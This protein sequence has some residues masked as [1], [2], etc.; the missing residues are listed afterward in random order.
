MHAITIIYRC[1]NDDTLIQNYDL[2]GKYLILL[3][4]AVTT[5]P[6]PFLQGKI[7]LKLYYYDLIKQVKTPFL[8]TINLPNSITDDRLFV[9][10][11][12][13]INNDTIGP[14]VIINT[15]NELQ[16]L[17]D[18]TTGFKFIWSLENIQDQIYSMDV[19]EHDSTSNIIGFTVGTKMGQL[20][21]LRLNLNSQSVKLVKKV[22]TMDS[23]NHVV[24]HNDTYGFVSFDNFFYF[25][26]KDHLE[27]Q[28]CSLPWLNDDDDEDCDGTLEQTVTSV[29]IATI[30][31]YSKSQIVYALCHITNFGCVLFKRPI[32][33]NWEFM[34]SFRKEIIPGYN[35][36]SPLLDCKIISDPINTTR[37]LIVSGSECGKLYIWKY[38]FNENE[39]IGEGKFVIASNEEN[40]ALVYN[41]A[42]DKEYNKLIFIDKNNCQINSV[43]ID[44][45]SVM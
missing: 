16:F 10:N 42:V 5:S 2:E 9:R 20:I 18:E 38:D 23:I 8:N 3:E 12:K 44:N 39:I 32:R 6:N 22:N 40:D 33:G 21:Q 30:D 1:S 4:S 24:I 28:T 25:H 14:I 29:D 43:S 7:Q 27:R 31:K 41:F 19:F 26:I 15:M 34:K 13:V 36:T 17:S 11:L 45:I 35:E 37:Y